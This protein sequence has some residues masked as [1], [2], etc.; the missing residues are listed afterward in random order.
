MPPSQTGQSYPDGRQQS[1]ST[2]G[3]EA[4]RPPQAVQAAGEEGEN[5][6]ETTDFRSVGKKT[7]GL[8]PGDLL[9]RKYKPSQRQ[10]AAVEQ[11]KKQGMSGRI[12]FDRF[13]G[14]PI[15]R[16][17][18]DG[19][20]LAA[21]LGTP[22][23]VVESFIQRHRELFLH[24]AADIRQANKRFDD[25][26]GSDGTRTIEWE[27][28]F[29]GI[30][31]VDATL[32]IVVEGESLTMLADHFLASPGQTGTGAIALPFRA[33]STVPSIAPGK[34]LASAAE[35][36]GEP[37]VHMPGAAVGKGP[38][39]SELRSTTQIRL[40]WMPDAE[41]GVKLC[42]DTVF[43]SPANNQVFRC[44]VDA[45]S[46]DVLVRKELGCTLSDYNVYA[47]KTTVNPALMTIVGYGIKEGTTA[48]VAFY[49]D[50]GSTIDTHVL[51]LT[52]ARLDLEDNDPMDEANYQVFPAD[53]I[54]AGGFT[55]TAS[56]VLNEYGVTLQTSGGVPS[57]DHLTVGMEVSGEGI[58]P[59]SLITA[60]SGNQFYLNQKATATLTGIMLKFNKPAVVIS[61]ATSVATSNVVTL[62]LTTGLE[63]G[64]K[65]F[66]PTIPSGALIDV[67]SP[68]SITL[69]Q[70]AT[71]SE[72]NLNGYAQYPQV[73]PEHTLRGTYTTTARRTLTIP[74]PPSPE[75]SNHYVGW[76]AVG[77]YFP[78]MT[79]ITSVATVAGSLTVTVDK[80]L[81]ASK[82]GA[83]GVDFIIRPTSVSPV[84]VRSVNSLIY[85]PDRSK[86]RGSEESFDSGAY[87]VRV[88]G[89]VNGFSRGVPVSKITLDPLSNRS[90]TLL[91]GQEYDVP[92]PT[93][94]N[95]PD[96]ED[97][98]W[99]IL[100]STKGDT[101]VTTGPAGLQDIA[102]GNNATEGSD[103]A[104]V[105]NAHYACN[106]LA[107]RAMP[108]L[109]TRLS[110]PVGTSP[111]YYERHMR[112]QVGSTSPASGQWNVAA[113]FP[114]V[115]LDATTYRNARLL[116]YDDFVSAGKNPE[117][118]EGS[119][120]FEDFGAEWYTTV[121]VPSSGRIALGQFN[122]AGESRRSALDATV[123]AHE[124]GHAVTSKTIW[125][126]YGPPVFPRPIDYD[127]YVQDE[128]A[129]SEGWSDFLTLL[130]LTPKPPPGVGLETYLKGSF[131]IGQYVSGRSKGIRRYP[132]SVNRQ[133]NP[134]TLLNHH[135]RTTTYAIVYKWEG[136]SPNRYKVFYPAVG[137][138]PHDYGE[139]WCS[140][141]WD[142]W[143]NLA[144]EFGWDEAKHLMLSY[145]VKAMGYG[146]R[147]SWENTM[148]NASYDLAVAVLGQL[149][150][151]HN[152]PPAHGSATDRQRRASNAIVDGLA[153]RGLWDLDWDRDTNTQI[154]PG[155]AGRAEFLQRD[156]V[157]SDPPEET[158]TPAITTFYAI[159]TD[160]TYTVSARQPFKAY[161]KGGSSIIGSG[162][163]AELYSST[164]DGNVRYTC[165]MAAPVLG[166]DWKGQTESAVTIPIPANVKSGIYT[167]RLTAKGT[168]G[169]WHAE[170]K[171]DVVPTLEEKVVIA[172]DGSGN[173]FVILQGSN[174]GS[175]LNTT[176]T[177]GV[178]LYLGFNISN[179]HWIENGMPP[180]YPDAY[181]IQGT[182]DSSGT[183]LSGPLLNSGGSNTLFSAV[184]LSSTVRV[185]RYVEGGDLYLYLAPDRPHLSNARD[186][187]L[188]P[189]DKPYITSFTP[190]GEG[191][192]S[193]VI[194]GGN[195][196]LVEDDTPAPVI[197]FGGTLV[198]GTLGATTITATVPANL[199]S[200]AAG[201]VDLKLTL[202]KAAEPSESWPVYKLGKFQLRPTITSYSPN[203][204]LIAPGGQLVLTGTN[205]K[206]ILFFI[207]GIA[208]DATF[209]SNGTSATLTIPEAAEGTHTL[210]MQENNAGRRSLGS[211]TQQV[212]IPPYV[213]AD[214][215]AL[216]N[217][218]NYAGKPG[219]KG[220]DDS[221]R[222]EEARFN[223]PAGMAVDTSGNVFVADSDNHV[224]RMATPAGVVTTIAG[225]PEVSGADNGPGFASRFNRPTGLALLGGS[226]YVIEANAKTIRR[227][228]LSSNVVSNVPMP[229]D[230]ASPTSRSPV[231]LAADSSSGELY[232]AFNDGKYWRYRPDKAEEWA[233][234]EV[235]ASSGTMPITPL[236]M[237]LYHE[238]V[239]SIR[240]YVLH[241]PTGTTFAVKRAIITTTAGGPTDVGTCTWAVTAQTLKNAA[242]TT[243][244]T[245]ANPSSIA[246]GLSA[247]GAYYFYVGD[248]TRIWRAISPTPLATTVTTSIA[249]GS[250][251]AGYSDTA[252]V[253]F[254]GVNGLSLTPSGKLYVANASTTAKYHTIREVETAT[255]A[256]VTT[257]AGSPNS[258]G[259]INGAANSIANVPRF[260]NPGG[261]LADTNSASGL[262]TIYVADS[263]NHNIRKITTNTGTGDTVTVTC[264]SGSEAA[265]PVGGY[266]HGTKPNAKFRSPS[267]LSFRSDRTSIYVADT[268][269][270]AIRRVT[271]AGVASLIAGT[272]TSIGSSDFSGLTTATAKGK[273]NSPKGVATGP[274]ANETLYVTDTGNHTIRKVVISG[275]NTTL[276]TIA[277]TVGEAGSEDSGAIVGG[278]GGGVSTSVTGRLNSP[279]GIAV[280]GTTDVTTR[281][282]VA[283]TG[284][285]TIR[286]IDPTVSP[287]TMTTIAGTGGL[288]GHQDG[289]GS[290]ALFYRPAGITA[291]RTG[292]TGPTILLVTELGGTEGIGHTV[293]Q[294][295][296]PSDFNPGDG[297]DCQVVTLG[298][299]SGHA[300]C[301]T[302][303]NSMASLDSPGGICATYQ[304]ARIYV[305]DGA[306]NRILR[307]D[308][309]MPPFIAFETTDQPGFV[310]ITGVIPTGS[311]MELQFGPRF[312]CAPGQSFTV[313]SNLSSSP[314]TGSFTSFIDGGI[315]EGMVNGELLRFLVS[316]AGGDG[317]D[318]TLTRVL[319]ES[320]DRATVIAQ[321]LPK[322][323]PYGYGP[324]VLNGI[325]LSAIETLDVRL[326]DTIT[327]MSLF[328]RSSS[329][330]QLNPD[331]QLV[332]QLS[333]LLGSYT[334][335]GML[336]IN[337]VDALRMPSSD[338]IYASHGE[339]V[340]PHQALVRSSASDF[341]VAGFAK[342]NGLYQ[343]DNGL[344]PYVV[345]RRH[346]TLSHQGQAGLRIGSG[347]T[348][349]DFQFIGNRWQSYSEP[350]YPL[351]PGYYSS[352]GTISSEVLPLAAGSPVQAVA[353]LMIRD[354]SSAI[355][356]TAFAS[357]SYVMLARTGDHRIVVYT[358]DGPSQAATEYS[359]LPIPDDK[360]AA[361]VYLRIRRT[362]GG[363]PNASVTASYSWDN[364]TWFYCHGSQW[365][366]TATPATLTSPSNLSAP[367]EAGLVVA[368]NVVAASAGATFD[369]FSMERETPYMCPPFELPAPPVQIALPPLAW[370]FDATG[371]I[372]WV[373]GQVSGGTDLS[374]VGYDWDGT[375]L[376]YRSQISLL[377]SAVSGLPDSVDL[378]DLPAVGGLP[379]GSAQNAFVS[380]ADGYLYLSCSYAA[381]YPLGSAGQILQIDPGTG[382][383]S[384]V[385][386]SADPLSNY[387]TYFRVITHPARI[388][389]TGFDAGATPYISILDEGQFES[390]YALL[391]GEPFPYETAWQLW[392]YDED[393]TAPYKPR[394]VASTSVRSSRQGLALYLGNGA[395]SIDNP[396]FVA[397]NQSPSYA[398]LL[399]YPAGAALD[400]VT[401]VSPCGDGALIS[402]S[403]V[404]LQGNDFCIDEDG[405]VYLAELIGTGPVAIPGA[406]LTSTPT[407]TVPAGND[408]VSYAA[409]RKISA[410]D[411]RI[412]RYG[413]SSGARASA[414]PTTASVGGQALGVSL[415]AT[416]PITVDRMNTVLFFDGTL[417]RWI[418]N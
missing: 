110:A 332:V 151:P 111:S 321:L 327:V 168:L 52:N 83:P 352:T 213:S 339:P 29:Q 345:G 190:S 178:S 118:P 258:P 371:K 396:K 78:E 171:V 191:G 85:P 73:F 246:V 193:L 40:A 269:N 123:V 270:H 297:I 322:K 51:Q 249:T 329:P 164:A 236:A 228:D 363:Y 350:L 229:W 275:T 256:T 116:T 36:V 346:V 402:Q 95:E 414:P 324:L 359:T 33:M 218:T 38:L 217:W 316:Y 179:P 278:E 107:Q 90:R 341:Y 401:R 262:D 71:A 128:R 63:A 320:P 245:L 80:D 225:V 338:S 290:S 287:A 45:E 137:F 173:A 392:N 20:P 260:N 251:T 64:M 145:A 157:V 121:V 261:V 79:R 200:G 155:F 11:R 235:T 387:S 66:L 96:L 204:P 234:M 265:A 274:D 364:I 177:G 318:L 331:R 336:I 404:R 185:G 384:R 240:M 209:D 389:S 272:G 133:V 94:P 416:S 6:Q 136:T 418:K 35:S 44:L 160:T 230:P 340:W 302:G 285:H 247:T 227:V 232:S 74:V 159:D 119:G 142:A 377:P 46:G 161:V 88:A 295:T 403:Y 381:G 183:Y 170:W 54:P 277:G 99:D 300:G 314:I 408:N 10:T 386:G 92:P 13:G 239:N 53:S 255:T 12:D 317:N 196:D 104:A 296:I 194:Q 333:P 172:D 326:D 65:V 152:I 283:D 184:P 379:A 87:S 108:F 410:L 334:N 76:L 122:M 91:Q 335:I 367:V 124:W 50:P 211:W 412:R 312:T 356:D 288:P 197:D 237:A 86:L 280:T 34:A 357:A 115:K 21:A 158:D 382:E 267:G 9:G 383:C 55:M 202:H 398:G 49:D 58:L 343:W 368:S 174:L 252:T 30:P 201:S 5:T 17:G 273:F 372:L 28:T 57:I 125:R 415:Y 328:D 60:K 369:N 47:L 75:L 82:A 43:E 378:A 153:S 259:N 348:A 393:S 84:L 373:L 390:R 214:E 309:L 127:A 4:P 138:E 244:Y 72:S 306:N 220:M 385:A 61:N 131:P 413:G 242:G 301:V 62:S 140:A 224:I 406:S 337:G 342:N 325:G 399:N 100:S 156:A 248:P 16:R 31:I 93:D 347:T 187:D 67:V 120:T 409:I 203:T 358:R 23:A 167:L 365:N 97:M 233:W 319:W 22:E 26:V 282:Y 351:L 2:P 286:M 380:A 147:S 105:V 129:I 146:S 195:L 163:T 39:K 18:L 257:F 141:L 250:T 101:I 360:K 294:I 362:N 150:N 216:F 223:N 266:A 199:L 307:G 271:T 305:A 192:Q 231:A 400:S 117:D 289:V 24:E 1:P 32:R 114:E 206:G 407:Y 208:V 25:P 344:H 411:R 103:A 254:D 354:G 102:I 210:V 109:M 27:Q 293:R 375:S 417:V 186:V 303:L 292:N 207:D 304:G 276:T 281:L 59:G 176:T 89:A 264:L 298:G 205:L 226:L 144:R 7:W 169:T 315:W 182:A 132:Y 15:W 405:N 279:E 112:V 268:G 212:R 215:P 353:G 130:M 166:T 181:G 135:S 149:S 69:N 154:F 219:N 37:Q 8:F 113:F 366:T 42:W 165:P 388:W 263:G 56:I 238:N 134:L 139:L 394:I 361:K 68:T 222:S 106:W 310:S 126:G 41:E 81:P 14:S 162:S 3:Q 241:K 19:K 189:A 143:A 291:I 175:L 376:Q 98:V 284:N 70:E 374:I 148:L 355:I 299:R 311:D 313:I 397:A 77:T 391:V 198:P 370:Q 330:A 243:T 349:D 395:L 308:S 180:V 188:Y 221:S 323:L 253:L 48:T